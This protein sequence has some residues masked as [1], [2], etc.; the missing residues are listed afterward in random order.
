[1]HDLSVL[2]KQL[3]NKKGARDVLQDQLSSLNNKITALTTELNDVQEARIIIQ[4]VAMQTQQELE[5]HISHVVTKAL[6]SVF[7]DPYQFKIEFS[8]RRDKTEADRYWI[9]GEHE[10]QPN[11]GG[12]RDVSSLAL[13]IAMYQLQSN[14]TSP[15]IILD[16]PAKHTSEDLLSRFS[17]LIKAISTQLGIQFVIVSHA[18]KIIESANTAYEVTKADGI[19]HVAPLNR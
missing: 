5:Y 12:V 1:M 17:S 16:E 9:K 13:R 11:G 14:K 6:E 8:L 7:D 10:Y 18:K 3:E 4:I 15:I 19:S 2:R